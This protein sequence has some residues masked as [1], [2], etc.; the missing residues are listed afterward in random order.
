MSKPL[1]TTVNDKDGSLFTV[2]PSISIQIR[3]GASPQIFKTYR[4]EMGEIVRTTVF[5]YVKNAFRIQLNSFS[6]DEIISKRKE[7]EQ[8]VETLLSEQLG[9]E[10]FILKDLSSGIKY[11]ESITN[12][13]NRK[14]EAVQQ[15][16]EAD[17][18]LKVAQANSKIKLLEAETDAQSYKLRQQSLT[19]LVVQ[20][21]FI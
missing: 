8:S 5:N 2:D 6:T 7:I 13:V 10:G 9:K 4:V 17:N 16:M 15:A 19:P 12:A 18:R 21:M 3:P 1:T 20:Q 14:N 11:P